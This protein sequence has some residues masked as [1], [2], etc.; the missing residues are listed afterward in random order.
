MY[1]RGGIGEG[2]TG[3]GSGSR[4]TGEL[5]PSSKAANLELLLVGGSTSCT[6]TKEEH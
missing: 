4:G 2:G 3:S 6:Y 5:G 1:D